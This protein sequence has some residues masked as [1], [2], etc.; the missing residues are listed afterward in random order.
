MIFPRFGQ[1]SGDFAFRGMDG[2][3][4][5]DSQWRVSRQRFF[6]FF[7][8][9]AF[10]CVG[11]P[12][13]SSASG[14]RGLFSRDFPAVNVLLLLSLTFPRFGE[15]PGFSRFRQANGSVFRGKDGN[16]PLPLRRFARVRGLFP[17]RRKLPPSPCFFIVLFSLLQIQKTYEILKNLPFSLATAPCSRYN[18]YTILICND[19]KGAV[20]W[21]NGRVSEVG[22]AFCW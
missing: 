1:R 6:P 15:P 2:F 9:A 18:Q 19:P 8:S 4:A 10:L 22:W 3:S 11:A 17:N 13:F 21:K 12:P 16:R 7:P 14:K 5:T 20:S